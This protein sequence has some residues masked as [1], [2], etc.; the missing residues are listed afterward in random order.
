MLIP[1][2]RSNQRRSRLMNFFEL[3]LFAGIITLF[4]GFTLILASSTAFLSQKPFF[5]ISSPFLEFLAYATVCVCE[6]TAILSSTRI[7]CIF[8]KVLG[9]ATL[10]V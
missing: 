4:F 9:L 5:L 10:I 2:D 3:V 1:Y 8:L 7:H 6:L